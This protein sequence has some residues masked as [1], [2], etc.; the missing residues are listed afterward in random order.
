MRN[1]FRRNGPMFLRCLLVAALTASGASAQVVV[2][3]YVEAFYQLNY[4][5]PDNLITAF[6]AFDNRTNSFTIHNAVLDVT[7][8]RDE[9]FARI[10]L[11][12]GH[13]PSSYYS[14]E[15]AAPAQAGAGAT[16]P[17]L[18]R[19]IQQAIVG[20]RRSASRTCPSGINGTGRAPPCSSRCPTIT[21]GSA[22]RCPSAN[23][24][25]AS[26]TS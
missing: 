8:T 23:G 19:L 18:W 21:R 20:Y 7:G 11:Q 10:V 9:V 12:I 16:G 3:G 6:R 17:E 4:N 26:A 22:S 5:Q 14:A 25:R 1:V 13:A 24:S 2:N 15:P